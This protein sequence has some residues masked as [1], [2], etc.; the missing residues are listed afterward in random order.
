[1]GTVACVLSAAGASGLL[2]MQQGYCT[3]LP[4]LPRPCPAKVAGPTAAWT[5]CRD[6]D[7]LRARGRLRLALPEH[8]LWL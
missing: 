4:R 2:C 6:L 3:L 5:A 8:L 1:M 7:M